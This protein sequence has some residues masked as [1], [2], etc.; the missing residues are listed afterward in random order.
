[1]IEDIEEFGFE[2]EVRALV[3]IELP[4][5][6]EVHLINRKPAEHVA[7]ERA[8]PCRSGSQERSDL[9]IRIAWDRYPG[10]VEATT[11]RR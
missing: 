6:S 5:K 11:A 8:L 1:M 4:A 3:E 10:V 7:A 2:L 9:G